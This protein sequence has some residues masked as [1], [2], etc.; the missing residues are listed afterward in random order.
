MSDPQNPSDPTWRP[1][2]GPA[3]EPPAAPA[4]PAAPPVYTQPPA[5]NEPPAAAAPPA[6]TQPAPTYGATQQGYPAAPPSAYGSPATAAIP[7][8]TLGIV[9]F[10]LSFFTGLIALILGIVALVQSKK[11][12]HKNGWAVAAIIISSVLMVIGIIVTIV[13]I[14]YAVGLANQVMVNCG[15]GGSGF[16][17]VWGQQVPCSEIDTNTR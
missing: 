4:A 7:G 10:V 8:K 15:T 3:V 13:W 16:V 14:T 9:A 17:E 6:Y 12:G 2:D 5:Y 1:A 11:A